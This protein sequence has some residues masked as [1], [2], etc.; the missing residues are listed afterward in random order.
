VV[1]THP[2]L[3]LVRR[4][5]DLIRTDYAE[6]LTLRTLA[7]KLQ[8]RPAYLGTM[9]RQQFGMTARDWLTRVRLEHAAELIC[10]GVKIEAVALTVG[11]RS[12]KNF[13]RPFKRYYAATPLQ[14][15]LRKSA[16]RR[17]G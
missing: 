17:A 8:A 14:Y 10:A 2:P 1:E 3:A 16:R 12:K 6:A 13:Y 5:L 4:T 11:Y 9:F 7:A 15:R